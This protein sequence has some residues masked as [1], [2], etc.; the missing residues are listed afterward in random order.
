MGPN[1]GGIFS[2]G[3]LTLNHSTVTNNSGCFAGGIDD[4]QSTLTLNHTTVSNN[5]AVCAAASNRCC[6]NGGGI[7]AGNS[8]TTL[9]DSTVTGNSAGNTGGGIYI[10]ESTVTLNHSTV[11][12]NTV[13]AAGDGGGI[14]LDCNTP[15][16]AGLTI[17]NSS[18]DGNLPSGSDIN[19]GKGAQSC[20]S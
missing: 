11:E 16:A 12:A 4:I 9:N 5:K 3:P 10:S 13:T 2:A 15:P 19:S 7:F 6:G 8:P 18:V 20:P 14:F 17:E 1:A